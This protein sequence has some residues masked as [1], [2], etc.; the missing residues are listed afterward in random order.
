M[1]EPGIIEAYKASRK[2]KV[3]GKVDI[4]EQKNGKANIIITEI[5][6]QLNKA[7]YRKR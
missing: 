5:P 4:E 2:I 7:S 3:R 6:Y 1:E